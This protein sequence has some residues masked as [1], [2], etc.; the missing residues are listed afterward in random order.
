MN[1]LESQNVLILKDFNNKCKKHK[2]FYSL[3]N[4]IL[5]NALNNP[6]NFESNNSLEVL[7][8]LDSYLTLKKFYPN[9]CLDNTTNAKYFELNPKFV[10][11]KN[12]FTF[13]KVFIKIIL[14]VPTIKSKAFLATSF[15]RFLKMKIGSYKTFYNLDKKIS[16]WKKIIIALF[17]TRLFKYTT[18]DI[19]D[20]LSLD[21]NEELEGF[22]IIDN[23]NFYLKNSWQVNFSSTTE[24]IFF[25]NS[26]FSMLKIFKLKDLTEK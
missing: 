16:F 1:K 25:L 24:E 8:T 18:Y 3:F 11:N 13:E 14:I 26:Q 9:N 7:M 17:S 19:C 5:E 12:T 2:I 4:E 20:K 10:W 15:F 22:F 21:K 6:S 23:N